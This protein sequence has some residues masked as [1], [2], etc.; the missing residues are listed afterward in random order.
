MWLSPDRFPQVVAFR[1]A[2]DVFDLGNPWI[3]DNPVFVLGDHVGIPKKDEKFA[4]RYG[5]KISIGRVKYLA[6]STIDIINWWL[7]RQGIQ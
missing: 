2:A 3:N 4:L 6:A 7:D 1:L 5:E